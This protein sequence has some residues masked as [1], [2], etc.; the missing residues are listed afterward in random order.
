MNL[1]NIKLSPK[2]EAVRDNRVKIDE[3][4]KMVEAE[5][6][7]LRGLHK[8]NQSVCAHPASAKRDHYDPGYAGGGYCGWS[9]NDCGQ[10]NTY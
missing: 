5:L 10:R 8:A 3:H 6:N 4:I 9:C 2:P 1:P 7:A